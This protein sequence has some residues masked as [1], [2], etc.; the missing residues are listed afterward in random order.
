[1]SRR[2]NCSESRNSKANRSP[3]LATAPDPL[4][5]EDIKFSGCGW[6]QALNKEPPFVVVIPFMNRD[7]QATHRVSALKTIVKEFQEAHVETILV[8]QGESPKDFNTGG[9]LYVCEQYDL[10]DS[11]FYKSTLIN[12]GIEFALEHFPNWKWLW[13]SDADILFP[14]SE[15]IKSAEACPQDTHVIVPWKNWLRLNQAQT[16]LVSDFPQN[17]RVFEDSSPRNINVGA[18]AGGIMLQRSILEEGF[19]WDDTFV[20]WG[21]EDSDAAKRAISWGSKG[22]KVHR[23][24]TSG[25]HLWHE[26]DRVVQVSN[27]EHYFQGEIPKNNMSGVLLEAKTK[28]LVV[29]TGRSGGHLLGRSLSLHPQVHCDN[30]EPFIH[31]KPQ[32]PIQEQ[33]VLMRNWAFRGPLFSEKPVVGMRLQYVINNPSFKFSFKSFLQWA[34][35]LEFNFI[36]LIRRNSVEQAISH[37]L[38]TRSGRW[39]HN[40][41][42]DT[43]IYL[44]PNEFKGFY[45]WVE[46]KKSEFTPLLNNY[47]AHVVYYE[48]L[49]ENWDSEM[50]K[51]F[52]SLGVKPLEVEQAVPKQTKKPHREYISNWSEIEEIA[53]S[54]KS[55]TL[56]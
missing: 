39:I 29:A 35:K 7:L 45:R 14:V 44:P 22:C 8:T 15:A 17:S 52:K 5:R 33:N 48:D 18:G 43:K 3:V 9:R 47:G 46:S 56:S 37:A 31:S 28:F 19:R 34:D 27:G 1:M 13:Q 55:E 21:W 23:G 40:K 30:K 25:L 32:P 53:K 12:R 41:Y 38:A 4:K 16:A 36:H 11:D 26:N 42:D 6:G 20:N 2:R 10:G 24:K 54:F 49:C 50:G 51:I